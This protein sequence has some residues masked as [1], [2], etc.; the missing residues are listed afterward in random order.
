[1]QFKT[2]KL[3]WFL[4]R[5]HPRSRGHRRPKPHLSP[6]ATMRARQYNHEP[7]IRLLCLLCEKASRRLVS[8]GYRDDKSRT[9]RHIQLY[10]AVNLGGALLRSPNLSF[11]LEVL[12]ANLHQFLR[13]AA[14]PLALS[15]RARADFNPGSCR[16][17]IAASRSFDKISKF[18]SI[19][20]ASRRSRLA[21]IAFCTMF[22]SS[23]RGALS[24]FLPG[25]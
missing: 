17:A 3:I 22:C 19:F 24:G 11:N 8:A 9:L 15:T 5:L 18:R 2:T 7:T 1:V 12:D 20:S 21:S 16:S 10:K 4:H 25:V 23:I 14:R 6:P 13:R